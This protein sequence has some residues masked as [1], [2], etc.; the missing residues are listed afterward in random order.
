MLFSL[1]FDHGSVQ[2]PRDVRTHLLK[3]LPPRIQF[4]STS[5]AHRP[6]WFRQIRATQHL[7]A[8]NGRYGVGDLNLDNSNLFN[9][10]FVNL[11]DAN[12]CVRSL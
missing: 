5:T 3:C 2:L 8:K 11:R 1:T 4:H 6:H 10:V 9:L 7:H 12:V